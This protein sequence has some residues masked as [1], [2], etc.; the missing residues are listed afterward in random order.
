MANRVCLYM[1]C[2]IIDYADGNC[3]GLYY[4][5]R[6]DSVEE[7]AREWRAWC[8]R[9]DL[10]PEPFIDRLTDLGHYPFE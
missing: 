1:G 7:I 2:L 8:L 4:E 3:G 6:T 9:F 10:D 5:E